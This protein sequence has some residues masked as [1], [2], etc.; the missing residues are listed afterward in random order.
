MN[1]T[2]S[3]SKK[4]RIPYT[5]VSG[6]RK[7]KL[8]K[9]PPALTLLLLSRVGKFTR[10]DFLAEA[11]SG[12]RVDVLCVEEAKG[13]YDIESRARKYPEVR[14][15]LLEGQ[16]SVGERI[17]LGFEETGSRYVFVVWTDMKTN[18]QALGPPL[19]ERLD[20]SER[21][22][23]VPILKTATGEPVPSIQVPA[24]L[25]S[26]VRV[27]PWPEVKGGMA[28]IFPFDY[29][30]I[31]HR[32]KFLHFGGFD[33]RIANPY[34]QK[35]DFGFRS[36][37]WGDRIVSDAEIS[38]GY[39]GEIPTEDSTPDAAYKLF[40]LKNIAVKRTRGGG[41]LPWYC[42]FRYALRSDTGPISSLEEFL[43]VKKWVGKSSSRFVTDS[44]TLI[45]TWEAER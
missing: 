11:T 21:I 38:A 19:A 23:T 13:T 20:D 12:G 39:V 28:S 7:S 43:T 14:F 41:V 29:C 44:R 37:L 18:V 24:F 16:A 6:H 27:M 22:C 33:Q 9:S 4:G 40:Y 36:F 5:V 30:G 17:N 42:F 8:P 25:G 3:T 35:M 2:P 45:R 10:E 31:Y 26:R 34:W 15:L 1:T 32:K